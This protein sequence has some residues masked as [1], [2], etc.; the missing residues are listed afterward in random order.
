M[1]TSV[2]FLKIA[3]SAFIPSLISMGLYICAGYLQN[4]IPSILLFFICGFIFLFP[5]QICVS[6][7]EKLF[8][9]NLLYYRFDKLKWWQLILL[10]IISVAIAG[11]ASYL[12]TPSERSLLSDAII[13]LESVTPDYFNWGASLKNYSYPLIIFTCIIYCIFNVIVCPV[14][15]EYFFRGVLTNRL[16]EYG[17]VAP[18]FVTI[19]FSLYHFWLPFDNLFR[20]AAFIVPSILAFKFRDVRISIGFHCICNLIS[21]V[22]F[23]LNVV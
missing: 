23:I 18:I 17:Y 21:T 6:V 11:L 8:K 16:R 4:A 3:L 13:K 12:I 10:V 2:K 15:E 7:G 20:I 9:R 22:S 19:V 1:K 14:I 5:Y